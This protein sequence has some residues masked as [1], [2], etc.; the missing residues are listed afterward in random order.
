MPSVVSATVSHDL[1]RHH[2]TANAQQGQRHGWLPLL[3]CG[4]G[5]GKTTCQDHVIPRILA[6]PTA[7]GTGAVNHLNIISSLCTPQSMQ[8]LAPKGDLWSQQAASVAQVLLVAHRSC[9]MALQAEASS[10]E[11]KFDSTVS[12][13][14][15]C[16]KLLKHRHRACPVT[17]LSPSTATA[18]CHSAK[19]RSVPDAN[20]RYANAHAPKISSRLLELAASHFSASADAQ[21]T[22][23]RALRM[24]T[25]CEYKAALL[26]AAEGLL[27]L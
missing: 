18:T 5:A 9:V 27:R 17:L 13:C 25:L 2:T 6:G 11:A 23:V 12:V 19:L 26:R 21:P 22:S 16:L 24:T 8:L 3:R 20:L 4:C 10:P 1:T 7:C 15:N 14:C